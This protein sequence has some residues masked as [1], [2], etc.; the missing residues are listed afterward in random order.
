MFQTES[1]PAG[2]SPL[3]SIRSSCDRCRLQK[4][5]C[6]VQSMESD[7]RMVCERCVRAKVPCA[8]GRRRRASRPSDTKK[9]GDSSTRRS[10]A[11]RTTNPEPT[12]LTPPLS[13]TSSTSE[14]T[15]GGATPSPT[16]ATSSALEAP[17]ETLAECEPDT[18]APTYSYHHHHHDSYQLG[19]GPPTPFPNPATTGGGSGSSMMDWDW[20]EQDFHANELYCLDPELLASAPAS[21]STSTGSPTAHHRALPDGG[22]GSSTMSMGGG[23][24][25][26]FSTTASVAGRRLPALIAEMQQR[27]EALE[28]GAWLHDGAQSFD[29]YPIGAVLRLSQEFGALAGQVL[30]MAATY[31]GGG[32]VPPSDVAGLQMMAAVGGGGGLYELGR[33]GLAEGGSSTATVLL[34]LGGYVFLVRLYGLVLGHFHA[35]LNRIP[36][37]SLGGHM[38]STPAP[39]TSPT[40]QLGELPSGGAMPDVSRIHAALG[41]LLAAL[42]SVE[43]QLGQGGEVAREMVVSILTQGSGLEPAK[44]QDGFG[45]L[46]EKV[47]SV[48]ELLREK[49]GL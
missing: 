13:T 11:P 42:H 33:G 40:L 10:T 47:R 6:T 48:K 22:S 38:H 31:G 2:G 32:G 25:T 28:N 49:M 4:L 26:P 27:L 41:M 46:G 43:E 7:G 30:G 16:L 21:T 23:A 36:S 20:L 35:H 3:Q 14:Q 29:H 34:V 37:G 17:L 5:K 19:E 8:F 15:L 1:H 44:L 39:T 9:Q 45:D 24:D 12:V 18:T